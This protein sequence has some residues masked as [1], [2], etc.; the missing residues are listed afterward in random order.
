MVVI[1]A[2]VA[3]AF[4]L[5]CFPPSRLTHHTVV[6]VRFVSIS[7]VVGGN[8]DVDVVDD[9]DGDYDDDDDGDDDDDDDAAVVIAAVVLLLLSLLSTEFRHCS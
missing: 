1:A 8:V 7:S 5:F 4:V 6:L 3:V 2:V 9:G